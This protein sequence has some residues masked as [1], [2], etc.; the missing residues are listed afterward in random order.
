MATAMKRPI[1]TNSNNTG[2]GY[3]K[4]ASRQAMVATIAM[5]MGTA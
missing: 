2:N 3:G 4:E 5:G 1:T